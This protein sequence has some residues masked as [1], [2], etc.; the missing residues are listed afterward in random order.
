MNPLKLF[1][2]KPKNLLTEQH[3]VGAPSFRDWN[4]GYS[5]LNHFS[6]DG[7]DSAYPSIR[8]ITNEYMTIRPYA[9]N[10]KGDKVENN[11]IINALYH[12]NQA[13]SSVAFFEKV[14]VSTLYH[15]NTY[16]LVWRRE[17]NEARPGG[18]FGLKGSRIAG[19]TF[20]EFP[21]ITRREGRTYY[22]IGAQEFN[23]KEV[24]VL[25]GGVHPNNLY[26][27][28]SPSV[29]SCK[30]AKLDDYIA[31]FQ[32]GFFENNAIP[33][34]TFVV[35]APT[36]TEYNNIVDKLQERHKGAGNNN[37]VTY[38]YRPTDP[39]SGKSEQA[40]V[41]WVPYGQSNKEIDFKNLFQQVNNR[42]DIAYGVPQIVKGVDDAATYA[43]A[44]VAEAT[45]AKRAVRPLALR[46]YTQLTHE[47]NRITGGI[48]VA[49]TFDYEIPAV[50]DEQLVRAQTK[51]HE[52]TALNSL[53]DKGYTL[54][55]AIDALQLPDSYKTLAL[56]T[57]TDNDEETDVDEG[58]EVT[59]SPDPEQIDGINPI[60]KRGA[61]NRTNPKDELTDSEVD[62]YE[63]QLS[64]VTR[65]YMSNQIERYITSLDTQDA[66]EDPE[67]DEIEDYTTEAMVIIAAILNL[68]G[69]RQNTEG[70]SLIVDAGL[71][72]D[73]ITPYNPSDAELDEYKT[74]LKGVASSYGDDTAD[75][76]R[77]VL[78]RSVAEGWDRGQLEGQL[79][80]IMNTDEW[81]VKRLATSEVNRSQD[82]GSI[83]SMRKIKDDTGYEIERSLLH[84][85]GET[86]CE[87][88][89]A[90]ID[91]WMPIEG[92]MIKKGT[93][94][95]GVDG[96]SYEYKWDDNQG[97]DV[98]A[99]G[100]CVPQFRVVK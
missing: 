36:A 7:Y 48:G 88:C 29:S 50:A 83:Y 30:W 3:F 31:D 33:A 87:F 100:H 75:S 32:R 15:R 59:G 99:N 5:F 55:S 10:A 40:Q 19:F 51:T 47:L 52:V 78:A 61:A 72:T 11:N 44:Q 84:T 13:D 68:S 25:P 97:H 34:G 20:L 86:P 38:T 53:V 82:L 21:G 71:S 17:G 92:T 54:L 76:I 66:T 57:P 14:A 77:A 24:I 85:G 8:A 93:V 70:I 74:Y 81:R 69:D 98:H 95:E 39:V 35:T 2:R 49:I 90:Y 65:N 73:D 16:I 23:D 27:G 91:N 18:D 67:E 41:E 43:N 26:G 89:A 6:S 37:N 4:P 12:P 42:I 28:Y 80:N 96:G 79:R 1:G 62:S 56:T 58:D 64:A 46:N 45:F 60:N 94:I 9:I 22:N 63:E